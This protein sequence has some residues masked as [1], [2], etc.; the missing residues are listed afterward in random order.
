[1]PEL[2]IKNIHVKDI[3]NGDH[4]I[5]LIYREQHSNDVTI[6]IEEIKHLLKNGT[7]LSTI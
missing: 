5:S 2:S 6:L 4:Y 1:M 3:E 7:G